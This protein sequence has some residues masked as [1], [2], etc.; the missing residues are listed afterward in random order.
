VLLISLNPGYAAD[1]SPFDEIV[2]ED[3]FAEF[4][5]PRMIGPYT[6][7]GVRKYPRVGLGYSVHYVEM[8]GAKATIIVYDLDQSG[9]QDGTTDA[10]VKEEFENID[11]SIMGVVQQGGYRSASRNDDL[12]MLSK[13]WLQMNHEIVENNGRQVHSYSFIRAQ[14][15]HFV[16]IRISTASEGSYARLPV[17]LIG[18]SRAIGMLSDRAKP[19]GA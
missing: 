15:G 17:F 16:K 4:R 18:V 13:A 7:Q 14:A 10:R 19:K 5:F 2:H 6:F 12:P 3:P 11:S 1:V 9:I 8:T